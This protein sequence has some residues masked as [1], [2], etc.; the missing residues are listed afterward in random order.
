MDVIMIIAEY[1]AAMNIIN[2]LL[3][4][5]DK[6]KAQKGAFRI[7]E[8]TLFIISL[9]GGSVGCVLGMYIFRHKTKQW[10]FVFTILAIL[11]LQAGLYF[12]LTRSSSLT[13]RIM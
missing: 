3:M 4:G 10:H 7:P 9:I 6:W 8:S 12:F 2:F 11:L 1:F 13:F 5:I